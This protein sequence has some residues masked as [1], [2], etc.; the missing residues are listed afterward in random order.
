VTPYLTNKNYLDRV[1]WI[2]KDAEDQFRIGN[3]L[4]EIDDN[5]NVIVQGK[6]YI[7]TKGLFELLTRKK[8]NHSQITA[9]DLRIYN[10]IL[11][12]TIGHL[13]NNDPSGVIKTTRW[14]K[15]RE[16]I[17]KLFPGNKKREVES[18]LKRT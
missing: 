6:I 16:V 12:L 11:D 4:I 7:G 1:F 18:E 14:A 9:Y 8:V 3:S 13:E 15:F 17:S 5:S 10:R 2:H